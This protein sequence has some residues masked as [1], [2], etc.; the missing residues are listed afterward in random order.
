MRLRTAAG[1]TRPPLGS[2]GTVPSAVAATPPLSLCRKR[3]NPLID[4][5]NRRRTRKQVRHKLL[6]QACLGI[7]TC[8]GENCYAV[9]FIRRQ[10]KCRQDD[11]AGCH[12][13]HH[14]MLNASGAQDLLQIIAAEG[15]EPVLV[16]NNLIVSGLQGLEV[17]FQRVFPRCDAPAWT[18]ES[19]LDLLPG[20]LVHRLIYSNSNSAGMKSHLS[21]DRR[22]RVTMN[23]E[24]LP[25]NGK[26]S[27]ELTQER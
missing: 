20:A 17:S 22:R 12:T 21:V 14:Q 26:N 5:K 23:A 10:R 15:A 16:H 13:R 27:C 6:M 24:K 19:A 8:I 2:Y 7:S 25:K 11:A 4:G 1:E 9:V 3:S 18:R